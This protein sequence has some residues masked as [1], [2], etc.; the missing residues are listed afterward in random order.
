MVELIRKTKSKNGLT[1]SEAKMFIKHI[2][3][4]LETEDAEDGALKVRL[5][6]LRLCK[7]FPVRGI[8][9]RVQLE[10]CAGDFAIRDHY[11]YSLAFEGKCPFLDFTFEEFSEISHLLDATSLDYNL[12][13]GLV[14]E[15]PSVGKDAS[16]DRTLTAEL[17][18]KA[19]GFLS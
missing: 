19:H 2:S 12:I 10:D 17:H 3:A 4:L 13:S 7:I 16:Y 15:R 11:D 9:D 1:I 5:E 18:R 14:E 8:D 6:E